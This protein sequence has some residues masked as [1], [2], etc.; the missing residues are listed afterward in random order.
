MVI[1]PDG[2]NIPSMR[3]FTVAMYVKADSQYPSATLFSYSV[4][5]KPNDVIILSFIESQIILTIKNKTVNANFNLADDHWHF[6]GVTWETQGGHLIIYIDG[7]KLKTVDNILRGEIIFGGGWIVIGQRYLAG[8]NKSLLATAFVGTLHQVNVWNVPGHPDLMWM[9][10]HNC[11]WVAGGSV[12]GWTNLLFGIKGNVEKRFM[13]Q[14]KPKG[15][16]SKG[17]WPIT[18][19]DE[20]FQS[21]CI[22]IKF[23]FEEQRF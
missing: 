7:V 3:S 8:E 5:K 11:T 18:I 9:G 10:A 4:P 23:H 1:L 19:T 15:N 22:K 14:C 2:D 13:T 16:E 6:V 17:N 12:L 20:N 21:L